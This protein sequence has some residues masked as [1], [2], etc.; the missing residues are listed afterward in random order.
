MKKIFKLVVSGLIAG[1]AV[2]LIGNAEGAESDSGKQ[3][4]DN[5]CQICHGVNG[6]GNGPAAA[7]FSPGPADFTNKKFWQGNVEQKI[8]NAIENGVGVMPAF[9]NI[10]PDQIKAIIDYMS[11]NF[12]PRG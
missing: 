5:K 6:D 10:N 12:K 1:S 2:L 9:T 11:H 3:L 7:S 4:F 8:T